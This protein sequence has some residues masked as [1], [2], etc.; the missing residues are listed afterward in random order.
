L[1]KDFEPA[2]Y[3]RQ[4]VYW[5]SYFRANLWPL[6]VIVAV[7]LFIV[8]IRLNSVSAAIFTGG[9]AASSL[10]ILLLFAFQILYGYVYQMI[11]VIVALFM[12]GLAV[13]SHLAKRVFPHPE[14]RTL[15]LIQIEIAVIYRIGIL[16][17][18][19]APKRR[20][21]TSCVG[22]VWRRPDRLSPRGAAGRNV[23]DSCVRLSCGECHSRMYEPGFF[24]R[25]VRRETIN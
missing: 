9:F 11:G 19:N 23:S 3:Y 16:C 22:V 4:I 8:T 10:E 15:I 13:G 14:S 21:S 12:A 1:N 6:A 24:S 17:R 25:D 7:L 2:S 20:R 18:S 5:L